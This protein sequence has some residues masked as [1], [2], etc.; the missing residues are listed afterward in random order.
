MP[1][2]H[3][4]ICQTATDILR[5]WRANCDLQMLIYQSDPMNPD[6]NEIA[7]V[8]DY[9]VGYHCKASHTYVEERAQIKTLIRDSVENY[10]STK[11]WSD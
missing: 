1:R 2:N 6:P 5:S 10:G 8:T 9:V 3:R 7:K 4:R 11:M